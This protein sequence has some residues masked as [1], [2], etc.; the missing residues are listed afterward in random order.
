MSAIELRAG[1]TDLSERRRSG[2]STGPLK[3]LAPSPAMTAIAWAPDGALRLGAAVTI[4]AIAADQRIGAAYPGLAAAAA[5][6]ATPQVRHLATLG[7]NLAQ[8]SRCW[9][10]RHPDLDCLKKG[11]A[12]CPARAGNHLYGVAFDLGPCVAPHPSTMAAALL[13]YDGVVTTDRRQGLAI[14]ALLGDGT[15]GTRDNRLAPGEIIESIALPPPIAGEKA[16]Y[17]RAIGRTHAEWPLAELVACAAVAGGKVQT[18]RLAAG[19]VAPVPLRLAAAEA[20]GRGA[21]ATAA[22]I[23]AIAE[24][25]TEGAKPLAMT[26][27]KLDLLKG[28]VRDLLGPLIG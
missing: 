7:G 20:T 28:L 9:Y 6:L 2:L 12:T 16:A 27:Y 18:L 24:R 14:P 8:R 15:D 1:G 23:A 13:A 10:Y 17:R 5:G 11:G 3:D 19:G 4:A 25:A 21:P 22:T 26:A